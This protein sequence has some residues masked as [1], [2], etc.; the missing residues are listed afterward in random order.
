MNSASGITV[1]LTLK[2]FFPITSKNSAS[3]HTMGGGEGQER[4]LG[5]EERRIRGM[6]CGIALDAV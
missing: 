3:A 1:L 2:T 5:E 6:V 4:I